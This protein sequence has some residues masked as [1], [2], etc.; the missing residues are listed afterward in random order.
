MTKPRLLDLFCGA[1]GAGMG[2][3]RAGFEV[4]GVDIRPMPR[5]PFEFHQADALEYLREHGHEFDAIHASPPCQAYSMAGTQ[6]RVAGAEYPDLVEPTREALKLTGKPYVIENVPGAPL[7]N[8]VILNG[9]LFGLRVR[10]TRLFETSFAMPLV[11]IPPEEKSNF[12]MGRPVKEGDVITPVGHFSNVAY[13]QRQMQ[14]DWMGQKELA[15]AIPPAYTEYIGKQIMQALQVQFRI[16]L[17]DIPTP[18]VS[19]AEDERNSRSV[20]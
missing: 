4:V 20:I 2:Y 1:G 16:D 17:V 7:I 11:L 15:Q 9:A 10:R 8:P 19:E 18:P 12:R 3:H 6:W 14:I 5:Y 13:A